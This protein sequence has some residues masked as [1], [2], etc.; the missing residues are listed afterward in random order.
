MPISSIYILT[1]LD[2]IIK[3]LLLIFMYIKL[4]IFWHN[5]DTV[6]GK[7]KIPDKI[8]FDVKMLHSFM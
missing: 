7:L 6:I 5:Y 4:S 2:S 8:K 1:A 3:A